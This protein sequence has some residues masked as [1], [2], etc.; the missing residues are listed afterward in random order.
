[1]KKSLKI[2]AFILC[3]SMV[4]SSLPTFVQAITFPKLEELGNF[5]NEKSGE[6][7][8]V[9]EISEKRTSNTKTFLMSDRSE[10]VAIYEEPVHFLENEKW[11]DVDNSFYITE[12]NTIKNVKNSIETEFVLETDQNNL[13]EIAKDSYRF[14]LF[15][16]ECNN[17]TAKYTEKDEATPKNLAELKNISGNVYYENILDNTDLTYDVS[18]AGVKESI[19][20]KNQDIPLEFCFN[21]EFEGLQF[22]YEDGRILLRNTEG[23]KIF[24]SDKFYMYDSAKNYSEDIEIETEEFENGIKLYIRPSVEWLSLEEREW[25]VVIDPGVIGTQNATDVWDIDLKLNQTSA[26]NYKAADMLVGSNGSSTV[27]RSLVRFV[28]LPNIGNNSRVVSA[29][30]NITAYQGPVKS[31]DPSLRT[32]PS[33]NINVCVHKMTANWPEQGATWG[34][35]ANSYSSDAEDYFTYNSAHNGFVADI[36]QAVTEWYQN[37]ASNYGVILKAESETA[38]NHIMQFTSS[39]Y[40]TNGS[41]AATW[42][43]VLAVNYRNSVGLE[44]YWSYSTYSADE[45]GT[46]YVNNANGNMIYEYTDYEYNAEINSFSL[47]HIYNSSE[48]DGAMGRYGKGWR[49]NL[50]QCFQP[51]SGTTANYVYTDGDG[52]KHYF[53][54]AEGSSKIIDEDGLGYEYT[55]ISEGQLIYKLTAKDDSVMKFDQWGF[56]RRIIDPNNNEICLN[57]SPAPSIGTNY[58]TSVSTKSANESSYSTVIS[59]NYTNYVLTDIYAN[60]SKIVEYD[61]DNSSLRHPQ[62]ADGT[63]PYFWFTGRIATA[64]YGNEQRIDYSYDSQ[65]RISNILLKDNSGAT[66]QSTSY[67]YQYNTT[68]LT[69]NLNRKM[70]Y[71]FDN[72]G[73]PLCA[74]DNFGNTAYCDY[75]NMSSNINGV[76]KNNKAVLSGSSNAYIDNILAN[77]YLLAGTGGYTIFDY[78]SGAGSVSSVSTEGL[79]TSKSLK[80]Q[81]NDTQATGKTLVVAQA[82]ST[83]QNKSYTFS[84]YIKTVNLSPDDATNPRHGALLK[85]TTNQS[86]QYF[87]E[88]ITGTT[89]T[90]IDN[91]FERV[92]VT[93]TL[94]ANE[95]ITT[96]SAGMFSSEGTAYF[97]T[98]QFEENDT[99]NYVNIMNNSGFERVSGSTP[100]S[101]GYSGNAGITMSTTAQ[102]GTRSVAIPGSTTAN[103]TVYQALDS[104]GS[105]GDVYTFG[106]WAKANSVPNTSGH[107]DFRQYLCFHYTDNTTENFIADFNPNVNGWQFVTKTVKAKKDYS[108]ITIYLDYNKNCGQALFDSAFL[109]RDTAQA[110]SYDSNGNLVST[111]DAANQSSTFRYSGNNISKLLSPTGTS[112]E[113]SYDQN[114]NLVLAKSSSGV[115]YNITYNEEGNPTSTKTSSDGYSSPPLPTKEYYIRQKGSGKYLTAPTGSSGGDVSQSA[116]SGADTQKWAF[117]K[118]EG[119]YYIKSLVSSNSNLVL[120]VSGGSNSDEAHINTQTKSNVDHKKFDLILKNDGSYKFRPKS[121]TDT[122][123]V[124]VVSSTASGVILQHYIGATNDNQ[125]WYIEEVPEQ[126]LQMTEGI[127]SFRN[128]NSGKYLD[129]TVSA[130]SLTQ[131]HRSGTDKQRFIVHQIQWNNQPRYRIESGDE[132]GKYLTVTETQSNGLYNI[133]F[134]EG[135]ASNANVFT[136]DC[137]NEKCKIINE[138]NDLQSTDDDKC[139]AVPFSSLTEGANV[140]AVGLA[141]NATRYWIPEALSLSINTSATYSQ[142]GQKLT[143]TTDSRGKT[144][145]YSYD[146]KGRL[147]SVTNPLS[148]VTTYSY[149]TNSDRLSSVSTGNST[150]GYTYVNDTEHPNNKLLSSIAS[151]SGTNYGFS[152]DNAER[153]SSISVG[154]RTLST[155]AYNSAGLLSTLTYGNGAVVGYNYDGLDRVTEKLYNGLVKFGYKYDKSGNLVHINDLVN[156]IT[157]KYSYDLIGRILNIKSSNGTGVYYTYDQCNRTNLIKYI[158]GGKSVSLNYLYGTS[159]G[160]NPD[161]IYGIKQNGNEIL[162]YSYDNLSR[163]N[164]RTLNTNSNFVTAYSYLE[165]AGMNATTTLMK[166]VTNGNDTLSYTYDDVGNITEIKK[167]NVVYESYEYD[168]LNQLTKVTRGTGENAD[169]YTYTYDNGGNIREVKLNGTTVKSYSYGDTEWKDLLTIYNNNNTNT[170]ITYDSIG[171]PLTYRDGFTFEWSN[172]RQLTSATHGTDSISY[173]YDDNGLRTQ[174]TVNGVTTDYYR[175]NGVLLGQKTGSEYIIYLYDENGTAY[176]MLLKNGTTEEYYYYIYNAQRDV[177]GIIDESGTQVVEYDYDAWG[178]VLSITGTGAQTIGEKN[179]IRYRGYY[180]DTETG[181]YYLQS[182]YYDPET[183]RFINADGYVSTGQDVLGYNTFVYCGNNPINHVDQ[184]GMFWKEIGGFFKKIATAIAHFARA[185]FGAGRSTSATIKKSEVEY[186]PDPLPITAKTGTKTTQTISKHGNSSKPVS[187]YA[188]RDAEHPIKSSSTGIKLNISKFTI[189]LSLGLDNIGISGSL[190]NGNTTDSFGLKANLSEMKVGFEESSAIKWDNTTQTTY[191]NVS[192]SGWALAT[193]YSLFTTG[194]PMPSTSYAY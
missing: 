140:I 8:Y 176:G 185:T 182:R 187:V 85:I 37:P 172:G 180:Y 178:K 66:K 126:A 108:K 99:P 128:R 80:F 63:G 84:A 109:Y 107:A 41:N 105:A 117:E 58:L 60:G 193:V 54:Q 91:G 3:I 170:N 19:I 125:Q 50:V 102:S 78:S 162:S 43:P 97:D 94:G 116:F 5:F 113:Y 77:G 27:Y 44:D 7:V 106:S 145:S 90:S 127:Y 28:N 59:L 155:N 61:Y 120:G 20:L 83:S 88:A 190:T 118:S 98:I 33:G 46:S 134:T 100:T 131:Y 174:K 52:T 135:E 96:A 23:E 49:L 57:Y 171:N 82:P 14:K 158:V 48:S 183:G 69:D 67:S 89:D 166:S 177:I 153:V 101:F 146:T 76:F 136:F 53:S 12:D 186:L 167:N 39:D 93:F 47:K 111:T 144:T 124:S 17:T 152:Y 68:V 130:G 35:Y 10:T 4:I 2:T 56:L 123:L 9:S 129:T 65:N 71:E 29:K 179:P 133:E 55:S 26:F 25:P 157:T 137:T 95:R 16:P 147:S 138:G 13:V 149:Q 75:T 139:L 181:L 161:F 51:V 81:I 79:I 73:R 36:T 164:S 87:S 22:A 32:R 175:L 1:M 72:F 45:F 74:F 21:Y 38:S 160:Q 151:P 114:N 188:K 173:L 115:D 156:N 150:V 191:T 142:N 40:G 18:S 168:G 112:F 184:T 31:G 92:S 165:G 163:L 11:E 148:T 62:K 159:A 122:K 132:P 189:D 169:V 42:R 34:G 104:A 194:Q 103:K 154:S 64:R 143:S 121:S 141:E 30:M 24:E 15:M 119:Y 70:T 110:Y 192:V 86:N 6:P